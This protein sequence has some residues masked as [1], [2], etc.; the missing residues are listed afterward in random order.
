MTSV[1]A[2]HTWADGSVTLV[3]VDVENDYPDAL[4]EARATAVRGLAEAEA[5]AALSE[6]E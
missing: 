1:A 4:S 5:V 2:Q 3:E 6:G